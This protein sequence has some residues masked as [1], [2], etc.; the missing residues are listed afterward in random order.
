[1][2]RALAEFV[3][4]CYRSY[5]S[6]WLKHGLNFKN[7]LNIRILFIEDSFLQN[8]LIVL[9]H[10][11]WTFWKIIFCLK[12]Q[13]NHAVLSLNKK[14][15][16]Y[17]LYHN[18]L[19]FNPLLAVRTYMYVHRKVF[20]HMHKTFNNNVHIFVNSSQSTPHTQSFSNMSL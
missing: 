5:Y 19:C 6:F 1:M 7:K 11:Q 12:F 17:V 2:T 8:M 18:D 10:H 15:L 4:R 16:F 3:N 9:V 13:N 20:V 14:K